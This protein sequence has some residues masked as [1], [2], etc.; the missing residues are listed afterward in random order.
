ME[1]KSQGKKSKGREKPRKESGG[2]E[3][4]RKEM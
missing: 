3:K 2:R 1:K 4:Q